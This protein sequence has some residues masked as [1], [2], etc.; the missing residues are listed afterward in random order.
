MLTDAQIK[1]LL[2]WFVTSSKTYK[3]FMDKRWPD[4]KGNHGRIQPQEIKAMSISDLVQRFKEYYRKVGGRQHLNQL[5]RDRIVGDEAKFRRTLEYLL[6]EDIP[7]DQRIDQVLDGDYK[8]NG[9][10]KAIATALL[11]A[12]APDKYSRWNIRA[13]QGFETLGWQLANR[14]DSNGQIYVNLLKLLEKLRNLSANLNLD[15]NALDLFLHTIAYESEGQAKVEE[16]SQRRDPAATPKANSRQSLDDGWASRIAAFIEKQMPPQRVQARIDFE[17]KAKG[18]LQEKHGQLSEKDIREFFRLINMENTPA[19]KLTK[20]RFAMAFIGN[21]VNQ[22]LEKPDLFNLWVDRFWSTDDDQIATALD[23]F[24][25]SPV[26]GIPALPTLILYLR[27]PAKFNIGIDATAKGLMRITGFEAKNLKTA[28]NYLKYTNKVNILRDSYRL[29]PQAMDA[30][31][32]YF[33][34]QQKGDSQK[35]EEQKTGKTLDDLASELLIDGEYLLRIDKLLNEKK[36]VIFYGPPGTGKTYIARKLA[37]FYAGKERVRFVQFHPSYTYEDFVEGFRPS[38]SAEGPTFILPPGPLKSIAGEA[39]EEALKNPDSKFVLIIDEIN[40]GNIAKVFGELYFLLE[41]RNEEI[42]LLYSEKPFSL[43]SNLWIIAT[44]NTADRSI[45]LIDAALRRRFYFVPFFPDEPPIR[46]LL[47]RWLSKNKPDLI[48]VDDVVEKANEKLGNRNNS[49]GPSYF[50]KDNLDE[51]WVEIIWSHSIMPYLEEQFFG[52]EQ[53]GSMTSLKKDTVNFR[54]LI[55]CMTTSR[56]T[57]RKIV[58]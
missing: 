15:F 55:L 40:R 50:M 57:L 16:V 1:E 35:P 53:R 24:W 14:G 8:V 39:S 11:T 19:G 28:E 21:N 20:N 27:D 5:S 18:I 23:E 26:R 43:P 44:M 36:Q 25:R 32:T 49:I 58:F 3:T 37:E 22:A 2:E 7:V 10:G 51:D 9:L 17:A 45:A 12:F 33:G 41:Y 31:L 56:R 13:E 30:L 29:V 54:L 38:Q 4:Q 34:R 48:W 52:E 47:R 42:K 6:N 46:G